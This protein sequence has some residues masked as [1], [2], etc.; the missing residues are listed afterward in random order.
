MHKQLLGLGLFS[1]ALLCTEIGLTRLFSTLYYPPFVF[2][3]LALAILGIGLGAALATWRTALR[4]PAFVPVY[5]ALTALSI[6]AV[7]VTAT[8]GGGVL[9]SILLF[10]AAMLPFFFGGLTLATLFSRHATQSTRLYLADLVGAGLGA[11]L[12]VPLFNSLGVITGL[13]AT[14]LIGASAGMLLAPG[15]RSWAAWSASGLIAALLL[16]NGTLDWLAMDM[17]RGAAVE[18][19]GQKPA[20][21]RL[22]NG[23]R[24]VETQWDAF[25]RTDLIDPGDGRPYELYMDGAAG[26]VMPPAAGHESLWRD[27]GFFPFAT[28]Q[29]DRVFVIGP[30]GGLDVWFG[31]QSGARQIMAVEVNP[32]SVELVRRY[33]D[34]N[35]DL[36]AQP[37]VRI[38][39]D[40]GR[41]VLQR[42]N[43]VYD[44]IFLS[45]VV[46]LAAERSGY[47]LVENNAYTVEAFQTY[48]EH[49]SADGQLA[50]KLYDEPTL[51]RAL[52]TALAVLRGRGLSD[53]EALQHIIVLLDP[54]ADPAIPLLLVRNSAYDRNDALS[55]G[56][57]ANEVGFRPL[58]LPGVWV[59]P[60]LDAVTAGERPFDDVA[61]ELMQNSTLD[62]SPTTDNRPFFFQFERGVPAGLRPLLWGV[63][64]LLLGGSVL[65]FAVQR[66]GSTSQ[67][68][69]SALYFAGLGAGFIAVEIALIQ[70]TQLFLGHPTWSTTAVLVTLLV[71]GGVGSGLAGRMVRPSA[72]IPLWPLAAV[73]GGL[74]VWALG[75]PW[76]SSTFFMLERNWRVTITVLGLLPL[77]LCM[78]M[79]FALGLRAAGYQGAHHVALAW[80]INGMM[81]VVG[82][83]GAVALAVVLG[84]RAVFVAAG[85]AYLLALVS[86]WY[87]R[88]ASVSVNATFPVTPVNKREYGELGQT[89]VRCGE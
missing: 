71:G 56:A 66:N 79:P 19:T 17:T 65:L 58:F 52:A 29:P 51:T 89:P 41:S 38:V 28:E 2:A 26:S 9:V 67:R 86:V 85:A 62:V 42:G 15:E 37:S 63:L 55:I 14:A 49:L 64:V 33:A 80:T 20:A 34:Y 6:G 74:T 59:E 54:N 77:A 12:V 27:I 69:A 7:L 81:T 53:A 78:G 43:A 46:T 1:G 24:I 68:T 16:G 57:V 40:E 18:W 45:Q 23:G 36:Y 5:V 32:A 60:P 73:L 25:A 30:G 75:W 39:V 61:R 21:A 31:V 87:W 83:V 50:L 10:V 44:L 88:R 4:R 84:Y 22:Q 47:A 35:G 3:V 13:L 11:L 72:R 48:L 8:S 70:Q 82:S 76:M